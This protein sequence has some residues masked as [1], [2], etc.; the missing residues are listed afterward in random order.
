M[1]SLYLDKIIIT[2]TRDP[3]GISPGVK[4]MLSCLENFQI[5]LFTVLAISPITLLMSTTLFNKSI[6]NEHI[7]EVKFHRYPAMYLMIL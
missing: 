4:E 3:A 5:P 2:I 6:G 7:L 1:G